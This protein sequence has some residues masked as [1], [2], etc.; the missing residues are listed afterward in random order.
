MTEKVSEKLTLASF[1][2]T[3]VLLKTKRPYTELQTVVL[4]C[5]K[6]AEA[7]IHGERNSV[8]KIE[9]IPVSDTTVYR[10]SLSIGEDLENQLLLKLRKAPSFGIQLDETTDVGS[11][12]QL[13]V[14][15]RFPDVELNK[16]SEHYLACQPL[17]MNANST[18][19]FQKLDDYFKQNNLS[20]KKCKSVTTDSAAAMQGKI[21]DVVSKIKDVSPDCISIHCVIHQKALVAKKLKGTI[22]NESSAVFQSAMSLVW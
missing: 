15:C 4:P 17:G 8:A 11:E 18:A 13:L 1:Q 5:L 19:I 12:A 20:W 21:N 14:F 22:N 3:H 9:E 16:I 10:R 6:I 7:L 2:M